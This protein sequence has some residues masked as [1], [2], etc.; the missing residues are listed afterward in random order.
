MKVSP[1][2]PWVA[3]GALYAF[4]VRESRISSAPWAG[5]AS[6]AASFVAGAVSVFAMPFSVGAAAPLSTGAALRSLDLPR[7]RR[8]ATSVRGN[9]ESIAGEDGR[10]D[11]AWRIRRG[12]AS[13]RWE[14]RFH[15]LRRSF[16]VAGRLRVIR[17]IVVP[18]C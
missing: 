1:S 18:P 7:D 10:G 2:T 15:G 5:A 3:T 17:V 12:G 13:S 11:A 4:P 9:S 8:V 6:F 16:P 14:Q